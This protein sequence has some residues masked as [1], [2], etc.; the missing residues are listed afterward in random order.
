[1]TDLASLFATDLQDPN[2]LLSVHLGHHVD[3]IAD[4]PERPDSMIDGLDRHHCSDLVRMRV[5]TICGDADLAD[6]VSETISTI[7]P[8][9]K[10]LTE[11]D[12]AIATTLAWYRSLM[13]DGL[14]ARIIAVKEVARDAAL[15]DQNPT[16][17]DDET[18]TAWHGS[19]AIL[20]R[21]VDLA[22]MTLTLGGHAVIVTADVDG[23][24]VIVQETPGGEDHLALYMLTYPTDE[25]DGRGGGGPRDPEPEDDPDPSRP[26]LLSA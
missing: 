15:L 11:V 5:L 22:A 16:K 14:L 13:E 21:H 19:V 6:T 26:I 4:W 1:M 3:E 12:A 23:I 7:V 2:L 8:I 25:D 20:R 10:D 17:M 9:A 18:R 24:D